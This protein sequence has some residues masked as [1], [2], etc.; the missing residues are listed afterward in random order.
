MSSTHVWQPESYIHYPMIEH[1]AVSPDGAR[2]LFTVRMAH[3]TEDASQF[4]HQLFIV[5]ADG[6]APPAQ[7]TFGES[8]TQPC[9]SPDGKTVAFIRSKS[10]WAMR[11]DGGEAW[12]VAGEANGIKL[13][14]SAFAWSPDG[15]RMAFVAPPWDEE[16]QARLK[17]KDDAVNW[18]EE[19]DFGHLH[20]VDL[21]APGAAPA[22]P[23]Q[24][25]WGR[26]HILGLDWRPDGGRIAFTHQPAPL[27]DVW[28][29]SRLATIA[30]D[31]SEA[32]LTDLGRAATFGPLPRYS[33][34]GAWIACEVTEEPMIWARASRMHLF[35]A[36]GGASIPLAQVS[37]EQPDLVAW[38]G[39]GSA[40]IVRNQHGIR[41]ELVALPVDGSEPIILFGG[42][43]LFNFQDVSASGM[44]VLVAQDYHEINCLY[45][46]NVAGAT[47]PVSFTKVAEPP[48][49]GGWAAGPLPQIELLSWTTP[50]GFEIEGTLFLPAG[51][52][53]TSGE[54]LPLLLHVHGGP[55]SVFF[56]EYV[57]RPYYYTPAALCE[58]GIAVLRCNPRGSGG[59]GWDFRLANRRDWGGGDYRDLQQGVDTVIDLGIADPDRLGISGWSYGGFMSSWALTQ[60]DRFR[61]ASIGAPVTN[62][63][64]FNGTADIPGFVPDYMMGVEFWDDPAIYRERSPMFHVKGVTTPAIMQHGGADERVPVEQGLQYYNALKRQGVPVELH[65]YPREPH[66]F[67]EPRHLIHASRRNLDWFSEM[68]LGETKG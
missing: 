50:D 56:R 17:A 30:A 62:L 60:T 39:D 5:P 28:T 9:F 3:M 22:Q 46:A 34:D 29:E 41:T 48:L 45:A 43:K 25:T 26:L 52:D 31:G 14:V 47:G 40:V 11:A 66:N 27:A 61:A 23:T 32:E 63:M 68:L 55:M 15:T 44:A 8:A 2:I 54:K 12:P 35:P 19:Y 49:P 53:R 18:R 38:A 1:V 4:R 57:G 65:I 10:L 7:L 67:T 16:R 6:G 13:G 37:D 64:S 21:P 36:E 42:E 24:L 20:G 51:Y 59:Y 33:P 58:R